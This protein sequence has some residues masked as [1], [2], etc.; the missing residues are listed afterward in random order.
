MRSPV[1]KEQAASNLE[2]VGSKLLLSAFQLSV[3]RNVSILSL[4]MGTV[5]PFVPWA[6]EEVPFLS[7]S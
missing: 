1:K 6:Y 2:H 7:Y 3:I 5:S 4:F